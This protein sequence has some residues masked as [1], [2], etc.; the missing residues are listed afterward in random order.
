MANLT[1]YARNSK[2]HSPNQIKQIASSIKEFGFINPIIA[3]GTGTI[4]AG[5]GRLEAALQLGMATVPCVRVEHMTERQRRAYV[6]A[7]NRLA[8]IG[9]EWDTEMLGLEV[10]DLG[11]HDKWEL[12][13]LL[14]LE[15][16]DELADEI[17]Q[18]GLAQAIQL[19]PAKEYAVILCADSKEWEELKVALNLVPVRRGGYKHGSP[20]DAVG[21]QRVVKAADF[22]QRYG[23]NAD[24]NSNT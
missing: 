6:I 7:D 14:G 18:S 4:I 23:G 10:D 8:E 12:G 2:K 19:E 20:F 16:D 24:A 3:D 22:L 5:H 17:E 1:P 15:S 11:L 9:T 21:T 13:E